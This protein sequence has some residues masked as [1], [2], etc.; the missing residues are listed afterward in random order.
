MELLKVALTSVG[1]IAALFLLTKWIG[2][3]QMSELNMFDYI[4]GITIGSIAAE[5]ATSLETEFTKPLLAMVIY[6]AATVLIDILTSK[7]GA[8]RRLFSGETILLMDNGK[9]YK[10][11][12]TKARL[13]LDEFLAQCRVK[14]YFDIQQIQTAVLEPNGQLSIFPRSGDRPA[15]PN[16][17]HLNP[18]PER[19]A[20]PLVADGKVM[21]KNLTYIG[22]NTEWL[23]N[24][25]KT[26]GYPETKE[27]FLALWNENGPIM[28]FKSMEGAPEKG[29]LQ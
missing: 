22:R 25:L 2:N 11:N 26:A 21:E 15:T 7:S 5:M 10:K 6:G 29:I 14:G 16:D 23:Q 24:E 13:D 27:I 28:I 1:S 20:V 19:V 12:F 9:L 18:P 4:N 8:V 3:R 17:L